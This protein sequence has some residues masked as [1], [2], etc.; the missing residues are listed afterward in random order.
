M[1]TLFKITALFADFFVGFIFNVFSS[2]FFSVLCFPINTIVRTI[3]TVYSYN[4]SLDKPSKF[5]YIM[6]Q[7]SWG[8]L[9]YLLGSLVGLGT[10]LFALL[11]NVE[12][13]KNTPV[14]K[15]YN[16][17]DSQLIALRNGTFC[18]A[19]YILVYYFITFI[20][21]YAY[22]KLNDSNDHRG[23]EI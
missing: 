5:K 6:I 19:G 2:G 21:A 12:W 23:E 15:I 14:A 17:V 20:M 13:F 10:Y 4:N 11:P 7:T 9:S 18:I 8:G 3:S 1:V 22:I 16:T